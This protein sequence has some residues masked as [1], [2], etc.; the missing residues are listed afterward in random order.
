MQSTDHTLLRAPQA[1]EYLGVSEAMLAK[2]RLR[3][4]GPRYSKLGA[5]VIV[6]D[7]AELA[8][9]V[10]AGQRASTSDNPSAIQAA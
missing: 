3:G 2:L 6:Y 7:R 5:R 10:E 4:G 8:R 1:A 9:W